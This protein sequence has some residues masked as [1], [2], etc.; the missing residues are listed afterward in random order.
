MDIDILQVKQLLI[1]IDKKNV[2]HV[3][4]VIEINW[5]SM[6]AK[7]Y[8]TNGACFLSQKRDWWLGQNNFADLKQFT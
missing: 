8:L 6:V 1:F 5:T 7:K 4:W 3:L 2:L